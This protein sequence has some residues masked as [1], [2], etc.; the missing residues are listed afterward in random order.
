[1]NQCLVLP[2]C[3]LLTLYLNYCHQIKP[4][5]LSRGLSESGIDTTLIGLGNFISRDVLLKA[6]EV[7]ERIGCS[8]ASFL[9]FLPLLYFV[10]YT[11]ERYWTLN[12]FG[13]LNLNL[14]HNA[15]QHLVNHY[16]HSPTYLTGKK[17]MLKGLERHWVTEIL[18]LYIY[19]IQWCFVVS[20]Q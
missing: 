15:P 5:L 3:T 9:C 8:K 16:N 14:Q 11:S 10:F 13:F 18:W 7:L 12:P 19:R 20:P 17:C 2:A 4:E 1:M 6:K